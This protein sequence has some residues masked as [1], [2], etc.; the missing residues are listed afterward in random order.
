[1]IL[2]GCFAAVIFVA[3]TT[4]GLGVMSIGM[5]IVATIELARH[6]FQS[7]PV[8]V[9][10]VTISLM[11]LIWGWIGPQIG[12]FEP[13]LPPCLFLLWGI[14]CLGSAERQF[15]YK[16]RISGILCVGLTFL[17]A[18]L[19]IRKILAPLLWGYDNSG[20]VPALAAI[21]HH[22]GFI[23][24]GRVPELFTS[25]MFKGG[26]PVGQSTSWAFIMSI[27]NIPLTGGYEIVR[28]FSLFMLLM[29]SYLVYILTRALF[30]RTL[31]GTDQ[32]I[33]ALLIS[34]FLASAIIFSQ[35]GTIF[36]YGY[37]PFIWACILIFSFSKI[38]ESTNSLTHKIML[39]ILGL[40]L[41]T[42]AYPILSPVPLISLLFT[43]SKI[44]TSDFPATTKKLPSLLICSGVGLILII[45]VVLKSLVIRH[46]IYSQAWIEP[47]NNKTIIAILI[48]VI[49]ITSTLRLNYKAVPNS[50]V[51]F[52]ASTINYV[53]LA[54]YSSQAKSEITYY[55]Q[56]AGFLALMSGVIAL[57]AVIN[58]PIKFKNLMALRGR[59]LL[60]SFL[61]LGILLYSANLSFQPNKFGAPTTYTIINYLRNNQSNNSWSCL[62][63]AMDLTSDL[64]SI[65]NTQTFVLIQKDIDNDLTTRWLNGARGQLNDP[66]FSLAIPIGQNQQPLEQIFDFWFKLYTKSKVVI[67]AP[68]IPDGLGA[69]SDRIEFRYLDCSV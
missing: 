24:S 14:Y 60:L 34:I 8:P 37:P 62:N 6:R 25:D 32:K 40:V 65:D 64:N 10:I 52:I 36:W 50:I 2:L 5:I 56:K 38:S 61:A 9:A 15:K 30:P 27:V 26:Y 29:G 49:A 31:F 53:I 17:I 66:T 55:P 45:L 12:N 43:L 22:G 54:Y 68:Q 20:H 7:E 58:L 19:P 39:D 21:Y 3:R 11:S 28:F 42:Y 59:A 44:R 69:W 35:V 33:F 63:R 1:M 18:I 46:W 16:L 13:L 48:S 67:L 4:V 57:G 23:Y 47:V 51:I 41:V